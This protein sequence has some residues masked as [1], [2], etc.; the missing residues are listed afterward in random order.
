MPLQS[1]KMQGKH[2]FSRYKDIPEESRVIY[3]DY[4]ASYLKVF[5]AIMAHLN[6]RSIYI[7]KAPWKSF[8]GLFYLSFNSIPSPTIRKQISPSHCGAQLLPI[9]VSEPEV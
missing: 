9:D 6:C 2:L 3:W 4:I 1:G 7:K 8:Q 5:Q